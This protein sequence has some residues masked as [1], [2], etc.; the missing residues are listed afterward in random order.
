ML[1]QLIIRAMEISKV[2]KVAANFVDDDGSWGFS[3]F[4]VTGT[5]VT[6]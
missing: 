1:F 5:S 3:H 4:S 2:T 6:G